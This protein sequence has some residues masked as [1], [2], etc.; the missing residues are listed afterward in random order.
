MVTESD[1]R[2]RYKRLTVPHSISEVQA[3][4]AF[5]YIPASHTSE[6]KCYFFSCAS[7]DFSDSDKTIWSTTEPGEI[8]LPQGISASVIW[9]VSMSQD[10]VEDQLKK[11]TKG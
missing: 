3:K 2:D 1:L 6:Q 8:Y 4:K 7:I 5:H 11:G 9:G 10:E